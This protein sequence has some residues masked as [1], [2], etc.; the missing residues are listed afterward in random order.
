MVYIISCLYSVGGK[1]CGGS[2]V[3]WVPIMFVFVI[4]LAE[5]LEHVTV[6]RIMIEV[7]NYS[8]I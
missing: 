3:V 5:Y 4:C 6:V 2:L 1:F 8:V 7:G